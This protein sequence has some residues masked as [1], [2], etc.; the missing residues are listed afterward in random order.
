ARAMRRILVDHARSRGSAKRGG[1][2][3]C[4]EFQDGL[5]AGRPADAMLLELDD[6][7]NRLAALDQRKCQVV[8]MRFFAGLSVEE[9]AEALKISPETVTRDWT[10][11]RAWLYREMS[12][13]KNNAT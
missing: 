7:L 8:E 12:G 3:I 10:M 1:G 4:I 9:T 6:A 5:A 11:A 13:H 2:Q